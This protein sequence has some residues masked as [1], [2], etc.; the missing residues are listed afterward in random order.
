RNP[1]TGGLTHI[2]T[3]TDG[4]QDAIGQRID[5]L[6]TGTA[7][8][9]SPDGG[10]VYATGY[11][12]AA[13]AA[14]ERDP[15]SGKLTF[16]QAVKRNPA[17]PAAGTP[18]LAGARDIA[19]GPEGR[20]IQV[21][22]YVENRVVTLFRPNPKPTLESLAPASATAGSADLTMTVNGADFVPGAKVRWNNAVDLATTFVN[23]SQIKATVGAALLTTAGQRPVTVINPTP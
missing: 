23:S 16:I 13:V 6:G 14:F 7:V 11:S 18:P 10:T 22:G 17:Y 19:V 1:A 21:S 15:A 5:G 4:G 3:Y 8:A 20:A 12:D 9:L 2:A